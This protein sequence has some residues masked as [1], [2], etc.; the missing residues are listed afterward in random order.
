[1][2]SGTATATG[3]SN[4]A[5]SLRVSAVVDGR[6]GSRRLLSLKTPANQGCS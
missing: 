6:A 4:A 5:G 3:G 2:P 1:V